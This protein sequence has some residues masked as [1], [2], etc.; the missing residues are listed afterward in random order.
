MNNVSVSGNLTTGLWLD[1]INFTSKSGEQGQ[2]SLTHMIKRGFL[3]TSGL[4]EQATF[5]NFKGHNMCIE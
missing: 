2:S 4:P 5:V 3:K 1:C